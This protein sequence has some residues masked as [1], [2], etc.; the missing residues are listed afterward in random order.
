VT[1]DQVE[2]MT[3]A[4]RV[5]V[6]N[7]GRIE[8]VGAPN[9]LY[10]LPATKFVAG[11]I[12]SPAMNFIPCGLEQAAGGLRLGLGG[13]LAFPVPSDR[14][15]RYRSHLGSKRLLFGIRP[16]D[17]FEQRPHVEPGQHAFEAVPE[18]VEPL[19]METLVFF[20]IGGVEICARVNPDCGAQ[21][22][23]PLKLVADLRHVHLID[24]ESG[25]V[26]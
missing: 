22:G 3:L 10:H 18:V 26:L 16:E 4:D 19:G 14:E 12:G 21:P 17:I 20:S 9:D 5:V 11:F 1:H 8:Q 24:D 6:M 15:A 23:A 2:A 25:R 7:A 13:S